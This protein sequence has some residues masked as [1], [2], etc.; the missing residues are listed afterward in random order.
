MERRVALPLR[1]ETAAAIRAGD[2]V[3]FSGVLYT[4]RD[5]AH[6]R[7]IELLD[8]GAPPPFPFE[9]G[10]IY[11]AGPSPAPAG[12]PTGSIGPTTSCRMDA[13]TPRLLERGLRGMIGKGTRSPAVIAAMKAA[14]AVYCAA[15]GGAGA[16]LASR[17]LRSEVIAFEDLGTEAVRRLTVEDFPTVAVIDAYGNNLYENI[18]LIR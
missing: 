9:G 13:Y 4:A 6:K 15:I 16:L 7:I 11:Y 1:R 8:A 3:Y 17:V 12:M 14:G 2:V 18:S 10:V 5:A